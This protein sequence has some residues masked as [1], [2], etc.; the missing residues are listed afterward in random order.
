MGKPRWALLIWGCSARA[1]FE[2]HLG[3]NTDRQTHRYE[4]NPKVTGP[5]WSHADRHSERYDN[6]RN[7]L[8]V[9]IRPICD[10]T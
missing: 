8:R 10:A 9:S 6:N 2:P 1:S 4:V 3:Q 7:A 5:N